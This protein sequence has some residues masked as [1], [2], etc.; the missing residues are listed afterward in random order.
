MVPYEKE[1]DYVTDIKRVKNH[2][3]KIKLKFVKFDNMASRLSSEL[4]YGMENHKRGKVKEE[5]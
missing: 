5:K 4:A 3:D 1:W 2:L